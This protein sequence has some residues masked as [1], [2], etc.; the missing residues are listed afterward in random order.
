MARCCDS[1]LIYGITLLV[2]KIDKNDFEVEVEPDET[3][4]HTHRI[5]TFFRQY[6]SEGVALEY[7]D[8]GN[9]WHLNTIQ[10]SKL[11]SSNERKINYI[12]HTPRASIF[13]LQFSHI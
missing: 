4:Y 10:Q 13:S 3:L 5:Q 2:K 11:N 6:V 8:D 7:T 1:V 9:L 12:F